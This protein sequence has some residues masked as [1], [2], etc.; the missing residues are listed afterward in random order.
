MRR[1]RVT[2]EEWERLIAEQRLLGRLIWEVQNPSKFNVGDKV[3]QGIIVDNP[4]T[5]WNTD[6]RGGHD[7]WWVY[8]VFT[9]SELKTFTEEDLLL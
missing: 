9:G 3:D 4:Y 1:K 5:V 7:I 8:K 6:K 2:E